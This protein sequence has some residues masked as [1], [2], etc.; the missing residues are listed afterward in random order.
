MPAGTITLQDPADDK[1]GKRGGHSAQQ[2]SDRKQDRT[3]QQATAKSKNVRDTAGRDNERGKGQHVT[4]E[5]PL[6][7]VQVR[8]Q[9]LTQSNQGHINRRDIGVKNREDHRDDEKGEARVS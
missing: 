9:I 7:I 6:Q 8:V 2:R 1:N 4:V 3:G 5:S